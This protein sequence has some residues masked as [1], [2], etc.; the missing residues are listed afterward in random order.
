MQKPIKAPD[1]I[2]PPARYEVDL[3]LE[4]SCMNDDKWERTYG[5]LMREVCKAINSLHDL[6]EEGFPVALVVI[7]TTAEELTKLE[8]AY[9]TITG[10]DDYPFEMNIARMQLKELQDEIAETDERVVYE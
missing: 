7:Q 10:N 3:K 4:A 5:H 9:R 2:T 6:V 1:V 8:S